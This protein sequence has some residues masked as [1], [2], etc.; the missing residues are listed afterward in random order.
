MSLTHE[1][2]GRAGIRDSVPILE[3]SKGESLMVGGWVHNVDCWNGKSLVVGKTRSFD[4]I[5]RLPDRLTSVLPRFPHG[6][7]VVSEGEGS[8]HKLSRTPCSLSSGEIL[9][10]IPYQ[11]ASSPR[12]GQSN[13]GS[14]CKQRGR[15][16]LCAGSIIS[17]GPLD[18]V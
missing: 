1:L 6:R 14:V 18:M 7:A 5:R 16:G 8:P 3:A 10:K 4:R 17:E 13:S 9:L 15:D 11:L 2:E 12:D